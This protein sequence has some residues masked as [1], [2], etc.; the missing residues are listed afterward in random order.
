MSSVP[1]KDADDQTFRPDTF[2][3]QEGGQ[4]VH[5]QAVVPVD[6]ATGDPLDAA[7]ETTLAALATAVDTLNTAAT[8]IKNAVEALNAKT[9]AI[10]TGAVALDS[11]TL[12]ALETINAA[13]SGTVALDGATLAAL[14]TI[15]A[16]TG[17][18]TNDELRAAAL[19]VTGPL[20]DTQLRAA[21]VPVVAEALATLL[22]VLIGS[23]QNHNSPFVDGSPGQVMLGKR[24][25]SDTTLV[26][27]GDLNTFNMDEEG[28]LKVASKPASYPDITGDITAVQATIN[29]PVAGGTVAGDVSR[30][31]NIMAFCTGTFAG[32]NVT[33]EGSLEATGDNWF[34]VQ[35]VR[36]NANTI[37]TATGVLA[38]QP[39]YGW[40]LSVNALKRVRVRCTARTSGTQ[41]WRFVQGTYATEPIPAAQVSATQPVSGTI[42]ATV[43]AATLGLPTLVADVASAAITTTTTTAAVT[44][45]AGVAYS[46]D[47][48]V[49]AVSGTNP[50]LDVVVQESDD[51]GTNWFDVYHFPRITATGI[52]RSPPLKLRGNRVRYVQTLTGT[53]PSF[54]RTVNRLQRQEVADPHAQLIDRAISLTTLSAATS[55]LNIQGARNVQMVLNL[56]AATTPPAIQLEGSEDGANWYA[57]GSPITGVASS[58]VQTTVNNVTAA[59][60]RGRVS[61]AGATITAGY[62]LIKGF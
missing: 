57:L 44:P 50:T 26:A 4:T 39:A 45:T 53:T 34:G 49:T 61:T 55:S 6:P 22:E 47:I 16:A 14:E 23:V 62:L 21:E 18:L 32:V 8:A 54:T 36:S 28:R 17:G 20:T 9:T 13:I 40:K 15:N 27:D 42:T 51:T 24:R 12:A 52:Y 37:E 58:T 2:T 31:S 25:D 48:P 38:A 35:A 11:A 33:F 46:I 1:L 43:A 56:G 30:A 3:R 5:M 60:L 59:F 29:T 7:T 10:N 19:P 41:S